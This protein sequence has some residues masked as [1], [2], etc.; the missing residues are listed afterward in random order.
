MKRT[1]KGEKMCEKLINKEDKKEK[2]VINK[3]N[4]NKERITIMRKN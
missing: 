3:F 2:E 4:K 1:K